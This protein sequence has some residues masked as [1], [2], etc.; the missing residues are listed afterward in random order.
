MLIILE[1][2]YFTVKVKAEYIPPH[3]VNTR[4]LSVGAPLS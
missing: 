3:H 4:L 2:G 1:F